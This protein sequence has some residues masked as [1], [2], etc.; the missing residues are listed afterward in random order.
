MKKLLIIL[1][2]ILVAGPMWAQDLTL[3]EIISKN[4]TAIGQDKLMKTETIKMTGMM[5]M[6]GMEFKIT[7]YSKKPDKMRQD[8]AIQGMNIIVAIEG[9]TGWTISPMTTGTTDPQD[10]PPEV[11]KQLLEESMVE[12]DVNWDNPFFNWKEKGINVEL[13]GKEDFDGKPVYNIKFTFENNLVV[14]YHIDVERFFVLRQLYTVSEMGQTYDQEIRYSDYRDIDGIICPFNIKI[15]AN[16]QVATTFTV[17]GC[18]FGIPI[19]D[20]LFK[21]PVKIEE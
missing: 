1:V 4:L 9:E 18:E 16:G 5:S 14:N 17:D 10:L 8:M 11:I 15:L 3:D 20:S 12:P 13:V 21:K 2:S 19:D 7:Q 6:Q